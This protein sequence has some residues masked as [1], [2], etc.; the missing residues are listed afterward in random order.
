M[1]Y[2]ISPINNY[3]DPYFKSNDFYTYV[4]TFHNPERLRLELRLSFVKRI[5]VDN[6]LNSKDFLNEL[7]NGAKWTELI[8]FYNDT[9]V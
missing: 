6:V 3:N 2:T 9:I 1:S 7:N 4:K 5:I 8:Y